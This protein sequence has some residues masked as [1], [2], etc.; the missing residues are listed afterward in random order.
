MPRFYFDKDFHLKGSSW[1][2]NEIRSVW[3]SLSSLFSIMFGIIILATILRV[4]YNSDI[5]AFIKQAPFPLDW[6]IGFYYYCIVGPIASVM[7]IYN[8]KITNF[9]NLN[10]FISVLLFIFEYFIIF[11]VISKIKQRS[12]ILL[13]L[14]LAHPIIII[15]GIFGVMW[16][17]KN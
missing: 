6:C 9:N 13:I 17:F 16:L 10:I 5:N 4:L 15:L 2:L 3:G 14:I 12:N 1:S 8:Q 7:Y 11:L